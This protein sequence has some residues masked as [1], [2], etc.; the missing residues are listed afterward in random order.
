LCFRCAG[1][2]NPLK[3]HKTA[4]AHTV[5]VGFQF[6][7]GALN[8]NMQH[9]GAK[10]PGLGQFHASNRVCVVACACFEGEV[11]IHASKCEGRSKR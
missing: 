7:H 1:P 5:T 4:G 8:C 2:G 10:L 6:L 9:Y 3:C 11:K